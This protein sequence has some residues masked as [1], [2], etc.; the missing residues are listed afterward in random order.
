M[1][2]RLRGTTF[3]LGLILI[4]EWA[5]HVNRTGTLDLIQLAFAIWLIGMTL[6]WYPPASLETTIPQ[7]C[8]MDPPPDPDDVDSADRPRR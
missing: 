1:T 8:P 4:G 6:L 3:A 2:A 5:S 7:R